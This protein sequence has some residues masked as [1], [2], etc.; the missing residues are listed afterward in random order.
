MNTG[1]FMRRQNN[2][3][4]QHT[5]RK[6]LISQIS[7]MDTTAIVNVNTEFNLNFLALPKNI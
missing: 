7:H 1:M 5:N 3:G 2:G 6:N 4:I